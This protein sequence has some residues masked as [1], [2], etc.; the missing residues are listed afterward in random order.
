M[1]N[2]YLSNRRDHQVPGARVP[3]YALNLTDVDGTPVARG[4]SGIL[5][6]RGYSQAPL[7]WNRAHKTADTMTA[8]TMRDGWIWT[9]DRF[10]EDAKELFT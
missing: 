8:D 6:V 7:Y 10:R 4:E 1:L 2:I 5:W 3:G 9:G